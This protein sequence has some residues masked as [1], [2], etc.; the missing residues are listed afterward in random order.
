[1]ADRY[2]LIVNSSTS[3]IQE[4]PA[5][6]NL[7][8]HN[9]GIVNAGVITATGFDGPIVAPL[10]PST[11]T[12]N[13]ILNLDA[14]NSNSY[15]GS[16]T[17]WTDLSG[18]GNNGTL[19]NNPTF[20]SDNGGV[21]VFDGSNESISSNYDLSW[22]NTNSVT[23]SLF[24]KPE[25]IS[26]ADSNGPFLGKTSYEWQFQ[27]IGG[28]LRFSYWNTSGGHTNGPQIV[29][30]NFF[31]DLS[32]VH[33]TMVWNHLEN[34]GNGTL[35]FYRNGTL[36][37]TDA[38]HGNPINW[39]DASINM[40]RNQ[41]IKIG[42]NI[43]S[44]AS[45]PSYWHGSIGNV[46]I[47]DK[48]LTAT[49]V[50]QNFDASK[51]RFGYGEKRNIVAGI[52]TTASM[53]VG[54][55]TS[56]SEDLVVTGNARVTGILTVG[57]SSLTIT[58]R[59]INAAGV[60]TCGNFKTG[61]SNVHSVGIEAAAI[62][63][64][65]AD[66]PIGAGATIY[67]SGAAVF[68]GTVTAGGL[69]VDGNITVGG[70]L[71]YNDVKS[72][73]SIGIITARSNIV[74]QGNIIGDG[75]TNI[76]GM[77]NFTA[78]TY[79]GSGANLTG[80]DA[81]QIFTNNTSVQTVDTG[82][83]GHVKF[84]TDGGERVRVSKDGAIGLGGA[85]Y[86][87]SGQVIHSQGSGSA[88]VWSTFQ[89]VP[90]GVIMM[91]SGAEGAIPSGWYL[92]NGQNSTPDLRNK[93]IVGAGS[94]SSYSVGNTGG[95][96]SV[97]LSTS[98]IPAH[99][100]TTSNHSHNAS[101]SDPGHGHSMSISDPGHSHNTSVTGAKLF[102]GYGGAHVPYGGGGGYPGTHF[103]MSNANT[104]V[105]MSA[106]NANTGLS[107]SLGNANPSTNNTGGGGSH[108]NRPPYYALCYI[109]KS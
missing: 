96:N 25:A 102:P 64:L 78:T 13:L 99:S 67:N 87:S 80:I 93:F 109:M 72:V 54:G 57:T 18:N 60:A 88:A 58:D 75:A 101:V 95:A 86:G 65:G 79:Y 1:M 48:A 3:K 11:I 16:G 61:S 5:G 84:T 59:D 8:L 71:T 40:N 35:T 104:G 62:N 29:F 24:V 108:E 42:G 76:S 4:L 17:T 85:N 36:Y 15:S 82:S 66:T 26:G 106:S 31:T 43:Y 12:D 52:N 2:P 30:N 44:W 7:D 46:V 53:R 49:E 77:N 51:E 69:E 91:W 45:Q 50:K 34:S 97:T 98:Q 68:T 83:N 22:N 21:F 107:V 32:P 81:T 41:G 55:D 9:N 73:D 28:T 89:G 103:N 38:S 70:E 100:H 37:D 33:I 63:S 23:I 6:G 90:S 27:Q 10:V 105:N 92:C 19:V 20:S 74:A 56:S 47:Y 14:G 94:G 39:T